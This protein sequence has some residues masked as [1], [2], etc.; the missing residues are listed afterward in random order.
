MSPTS[1]AGGWDDV[2]VGAGTAGSVLASRLC[3]DPDRRVLL[4]E[5]GPDCV[6]P[7]EPPNI[8]GVPVVGGYNWDLTAYTGSEPTGRQAL[9]PLG[10]LVGGTSGINGA[11]ALRGLPG[12]FDEWAAAGC[13]EWAWDRVLPWYR[14]VEADADVKDSLHGNDGPVPV[15]RARPAELDP[16]STAFLSSCRALGL[17][18]LS[19]LNG[20]PESGAG[21]IPT[22][23]VGQRRMSSADTHLAG[24]RDRPNLT[25]WDRC[26][27]SRVLLDGDRVVG[28]EVL[29]DGR[30]QRVDADRV[31]LAAGG[32]GTPL[33][34]QR[35]GIGD[36]VRLAAR[37][38]PSRIDLPGVGENL[39]DHPA[40]PIWTI[41]APGNCHG[42]DPWYQVMA[43]ASSDG[44]E[45][46]TAVFLANN[47]ETGNLPDSAVLGNRVAA[48]VSAVL[49]KPRS[50]GRVN[51]AGPRPDSAPEI[52]L[53]LA[54]VPE[55][56]ERLM[57]AVRLAWSV[58]RAE[59][60]AGR[61]RHVLAWTDRMVYE[62]R[63][64]R[65]ALHRWTVPLFHAAGT[66]R[67]GPGDDAMAVVDQRCRVHQVSGLFVCDSSVM[68]SQP[69]AP[70]SLTCL[71]IAERVAQ[72]MT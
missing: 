39:R 32:I 5:A 54:S 1:T 55:D 4:V 15:R 50:R 66:A 44:C 29:R 53:G 8:R 42:G 59:P 41:P 64:L 49:L 67:M 62:D 36:P 24:V 30:L 25:L 10:R 19:D 33:V 31:T 12:D 70:P 27:V 21:T 2:V 63:L 20:V 72:W 52:V 18:V 46:D 38:I 51:P 58:V 3:A 43:R 71:M 28:V 48:M 68:P 14:Q 60:F 23:G 9:Y 7:A 17:P 11:I 35:S 45:P 26:V 16:M 22:N 61:L 6:G 13:P 34:L 57:S 37:G 65:A 69:S 56:V 40:V 47:I